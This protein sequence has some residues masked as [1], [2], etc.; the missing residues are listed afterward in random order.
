MKHAS[1]EA[2]FSPK[3]PTYPSIKFNMS[4]RTASATRGRDP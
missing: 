2:K 1:S 3:I 4:I